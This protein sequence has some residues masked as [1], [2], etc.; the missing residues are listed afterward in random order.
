VAETK[1]QERT[2][3]GEGNGPGGEAVKPELVTGTVPTGLED[4]GPWVK[5]RYADGNKSAL[6]TY[7]AMLDIGDALNKAKKLLK[8]TKAYGEWFENQD[9]PFGTRWGNELQ[10]AGAKKAQVL[11]VIRKQIDAGGVGVSFRGALR[12][13]EGKVLPECD[14]N[15][16]SS[17]TTEE[18]EDEDDSGAPE[19]PDNPPPEK[20]QG[21]KSGP[22]PVLTPSDDAPFHRQ[23]GRRR[24]D[25]DRE[26][27]H[28][29]HR[30][31]RSRRRRRDPRRARRTRE[32]LP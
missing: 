2:R 17:Q 5:A 14:R 4:I 26:Q 20:E 21:E 22:M 8:T 6:A 11:K 23:L 1:T 24:W 10:R 15:S 7:E 30:Q 32:R 25:R 12:V 27:R 18:R 13:V 19:R 29:V 3:A 31:A 9:F 28:P 16:G